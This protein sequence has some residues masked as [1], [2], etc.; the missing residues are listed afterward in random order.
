MDMKKYLELMQAVFALICLCYE[1]I[2]VVGQNPQNLK[3]INVFG[4]IQ[5]EVHKREL[6]MSARP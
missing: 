6:K 5:I 2:G 1:K 3:K 4:N